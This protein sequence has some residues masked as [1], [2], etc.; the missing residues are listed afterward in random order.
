MS[1]VTLKDILPQAMEGNYAVGAFDTF[2]PLFTEGII[3][4]AE[5]KNVPIILMLGE[6]TFDEPTAEYFMNYNIER[7][8]RSKVPVVLHL[9]HGSSF[10]AVMKAIHVGC[11]SVMI[12]G[13]SLSYEENVT[14]TK[15]VVEAAHACGVSV[16]AEIGHVAGNEGEFRDANVADESAYTEVE[17]AVRFYG[18]T[19][20]DTLAVAIGTVHGV[21]KGEPKLDFERLSKIRKELPVPLV[22]H[23]GSGLSDENFIR[24]IACGM[25]KV[26]FFTG[27]SIAATDAV[28]EYFKEN[29][30]A[31]IGE[32]IYIA[33]DSIRETVKHAITTFGT[34]PIA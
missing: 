9:D 29:A 24:A 31:D 25:N 16:E 22:M 33:Q 3:S 11:T 18:E 7:C 32:A 12:D 30:K 27:M 10:E 28:A 20:V 15:K 34:K 17:D 1:L 21:Y 19:K 6:F 5:E 26:N 4:A 14:L 13:S 2:D 8:R 23:G